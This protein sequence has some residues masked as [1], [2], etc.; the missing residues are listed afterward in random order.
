M[1][2]RPGFSSLTLSEGKKI[3]NTIK[4]K[5]PF[6]SYIAGSIRREEP[7]LNDIDI[8]IIPGNY[9]L[10]DIMDKIFD[11]IERFG[12]HIINGIYYHNNKKVLI[13]FFITT[14]EELP[15]SMLQY[16]GPKSY[17]IRI[18]RYVRDQYNWLLNQYGLFYAGTNRKVIKSSNIKTEK[19]IIHFIGTTYYKPIDRL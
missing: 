13:D 17:N 3:Y 12:N 6:P 7:I 1:P 19:D 18:R 9:K 16:T 15:Y 4:K 11:K 8:V 5:L 10:D 14:R 2:K